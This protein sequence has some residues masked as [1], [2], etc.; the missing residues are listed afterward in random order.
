[1]HQ[2][3]VCWQKLWTQLKLTVT[4]KRQKWC[5][6][7]R[8]DRKRIGIGIEGNSNRGNQSWCWSWSS[9]PLATW[10]EQPTHWKRPWCWER[11]K[12]GGEGGEKRVRWL[13]GITDSVGMSLSKL[14]E[15]VKG[16]EAWGAAVHTV[17]KSRTRFSNWTTVSTAVCGRTFFLIRKFVRWLILVCFIKLII[18]NI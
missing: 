17:S 7:E 12:A 2:F 1:M 10:C 9:N 18:W 15:M 8:W 14:R 16:R 13:D 4:I 3:S 5:W 6:R 11:L